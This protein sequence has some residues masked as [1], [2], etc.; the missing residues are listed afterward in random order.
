MLSSPAEWLRRPTGT[1]PEVS[2]LSQQFFTAKKNPKNHIKI[3]A[4][5]LLNLT[6]PFSPDSNKDLISLHPITT[7]SNVQAII[8]IKEMNTNDN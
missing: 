4:Y 5:G 8:W 3:P 7:R 6:N 1:S 2:S